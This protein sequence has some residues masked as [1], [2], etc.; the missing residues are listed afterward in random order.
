MK[1]LALDLG[2]VHT[3]TAISDITGLLAK[4]YKTIP[5]GQLE[6]FLK[7]IIKEEEIDKIIIGYPKTMAGKISAQTQK[8]INTKTELEKK[9]PKIIWILWDERLSSK[10]AEQLKKIKDKEDKIKSHS[11]AAAFILDSYL[12]Y[13]QISKSIQTQG[14]DKF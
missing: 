3:G 13:L 5:T 14:D 1:I 7:E 12:E 10:K 11:I 8:I 6:N 4:P 2:D 9:F